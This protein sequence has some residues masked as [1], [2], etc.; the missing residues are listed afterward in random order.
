MIEE[1]SLINCQ[2]SIVEKTSVE[3]EIWDAK[4][5]ESISLARKAIYKDELETRLEEFGLYSKEKKKKN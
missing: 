5:E 1:H 4:E 2:F 3:N